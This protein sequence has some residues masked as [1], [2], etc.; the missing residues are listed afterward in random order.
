MSTRTSCL[1]A[2]REITDKPVIGIAQASMYMAAQVAPKMSIIT[3]IPRTISV[4]EEM[5]TR[6]GMDKFLASIR[7]TDLS[8]LDFEDDPETGMKAL[9]EQSRLAVEEDGAEAILLGC[10]GMVSF[11]KELEKDLGVPVFDGV[12]AAVKMAEGLIAMAKK[13]SKVCTYQYPPVKHYNRVP[14]VIKGR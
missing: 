10:A 6:Y 8:V 3:L 14:E 12:T 2:V 7:C 9:K 11:T 5:V 13:T 1:E 4:L